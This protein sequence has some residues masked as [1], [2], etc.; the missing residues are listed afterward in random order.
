MLSLDSGCP[1][2]S[3]CPALSL[4]P[5]C[6]VLSRDQGALL[7]SPAGQQLTTAELP[8]VVVVVVGSDVPMHLFLITLDASQKGS[9]GKLLSPVF[10]PGAAGLHRN[11]L[12]YRLGRCTLR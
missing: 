11:R 10:Y 8:A 9:G 6:P 4:D 7:S 2:L 5:G 1:V 3:G 12:L